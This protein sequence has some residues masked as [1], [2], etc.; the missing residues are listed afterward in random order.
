MRLGLPSYH[1]SQT[2]A[3]FY[4]LDTQHDP[5]RASADAT[6]AAASEAPEA[7]GAAPSRRIAGWSV[8]S[9]DPR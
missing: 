5:C 1:A 3:C 2:R 6:E 7:S 8:V 9:A 4:C